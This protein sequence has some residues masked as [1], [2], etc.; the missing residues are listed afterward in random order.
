[1]KVVSKLETPIAR[2][3]FPGVNS[4]SCSAGEAVKDT[5]YTPSCLHSQPPMGGM[6]G[7]GLAWAADIRSSWRQN[8]LGAVVVV[9][10]GFPCGM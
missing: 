7:S 5:C 2:K 4:V 6:S 3:I 1:M 10:C 8:L 9:F